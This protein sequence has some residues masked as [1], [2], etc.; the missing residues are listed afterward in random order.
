[1]ETTA[2]ATA[3]VKPRAPALVRELNARHRDKL[4]A[5]FLALGAEDR[6]LRFGSIVNDDVVRQY[7][8]S[9][10]FQRD[11]VF[12][13]FGDR[14]ELIGAGHLAYLKQDNAKE[15]GG[16]AELGVSVSSGQRGRGIG[17]TLFER[18]AI[19]CRNAGVSTLYMHCLAQNGAMMHIAKKA[20]MQVQYAYGEADAYLTLPSASTATVFAEAVQGQ[21]ADFD[22]AL[23]RNLAQARRTVHSFW[24]LDKETA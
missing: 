10:D 5:H 12:G 24:N 4:L 2:T 15:G 1:M 13:V 21:L 17:S 22:Y 3:A 7:V 16:V 18:A 19:R 8:A 11:T 6:L 14:L 20:G 23:K 9:I